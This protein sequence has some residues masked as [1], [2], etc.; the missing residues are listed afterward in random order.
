MLKKLVVH[1]PEIDRES[2]PDIVVVARQLNSV[3]LTSYDF[4]NNDKIL[5]KNGL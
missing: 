3:C 1:Y 2:S 4:T 5:L